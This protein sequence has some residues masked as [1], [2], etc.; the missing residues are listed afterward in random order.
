M[1]QSCHTVGT[2]GGGSFPPP[3]PLLCPACDSAQ[4]GPGGRS[5]SKPHPGTPPLDITHCVPP[6]GR[7][8]DMSEAL[9]G[10]CGG[11]YRSGPLVSP[12]SVP[13]NGFPGTPPP[14]PHHNPDSVCTCVVF[15]DESYAP[16][17]SVVRRPKWDILPRHNMV[18]MTY[19]PFY[20]G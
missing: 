7:T 10:V 11:G 4:S 18:F 1:R 14:S 13:A 16:P 3:G 20:P 17:S 6:K 8:Y 12:C 9:S 15:P 19:L 2:T 5:N